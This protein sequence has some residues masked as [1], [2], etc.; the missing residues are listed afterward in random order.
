MQTAG[1]ELLLYITICTL[2][3]WRRY[4]LHTNLISK[5][6]ITDNSKIVKPEIKANS[7]RS[8]PL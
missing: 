7:K 3:E 8:E 4:P 2:S 6:I 5:I 1:N